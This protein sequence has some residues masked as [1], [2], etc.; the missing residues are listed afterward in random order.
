M[1]D[2]TIA[3]NEA[4]ALHRAANFAAAES[5]YRDI[6]RRDPAHADAR[7][8]LGVAMHQ[9]GRHEAAA[10]AIRRAIAVRDDRPDYY[11]HLAEAALAA[12]QL[13]DAIA[14]LERLVQFR[15]NDAVGWFRLGNALKSR[16]RIDDTIAAYRQAIALSPEFVEARFNLANTL[17][18]CGQTGDAETE[19]RAAVADRPEFVQAWNN[20][21]TLL[22]G[23][24]RLDDAREC[25]ETATSVEPESADGWNNLGNVLCDLDDREGSQAAYRRCL[26]I[27]AGHFGALNNLA[28]LEHEDGRLDDAE[29]RYREAIDRRP[30][31]ARAW[32]SLGNVLFDLQRADDAIACFNRALEINPGDPSPRCNRALSWLLAGDDDR[33]WPEYEARWDRP[34]HQRSR[35]S[36]PLWDGSPLDGRVILLDWEQGLGDTLQFVRFAQLLKQQGGDVVVRCQKPLTDIL[37]GVA[38]IDRVVADGAPLPPFDVHAPLLSLPHIMNLRIRAL[39]DCVPYISPDPHLTAAWR[40]RL[41]SVDGLRIGVCWRGNARHLRDR[42]RSIP[43]AA[44]A[45]LAAIPGVRLVG[46]QKG[47][48]NPSDRESASRILSADFSDE[49]DEQHGPFMDTAALMRNLDLV[50]TAD[51]ALGHLAG[52][53]GVPVCVALCGLPEWRWMLD[54]DDSPWYPTMRLYRQTE[55]GDWDNVFE[56]IA[57]DVS[58][59]LRNFANR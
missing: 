36:R 32:N 23:E 58:G 31:D 52:A 17:R 3:L 28:R 7:H 20:L 8:L 33:G 38:G 29:T 2:S 6:L 47:E 14:A 26:L 13:D 44:F 42:F 46:L 9:T 41:A 19:Y 50:V 57:T 22:Q 39:P 56:R 48:L 35:F 15:P 10:D 37:K 1:T 5:A 18:D 54:R 24:Q 4:V 53:L 27:D 43:L 45:P 16:R 11:G 51:T 55:L 30:N 49:L 59:L 12:G 40:E 34:D 21:G 25:F